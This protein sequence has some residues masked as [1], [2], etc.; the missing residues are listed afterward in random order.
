MAKKKAPQSVP[1][2]F[3]SKA[4]HDPTSNLIAQQERIARSSPIISDPK[5]RRSLK[6]LHQ[7]VQEP[8]ASEIGFLSDPVESPFDETL[9]TRPELSEPAAKSKPVEAEPAMPASELWEGRVTA[10]GDKIVDEYRAELVAGTI[11]LTK[12]LERELPRYHRSS[13]E[14]FSTDSM[15]KLIRNHYPELFL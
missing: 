11:D 6:G 4:E 9:A 13:G 15:R 14:P 5:A 1:H 3:L 12:L 10:L 8:S 7:P 2:D